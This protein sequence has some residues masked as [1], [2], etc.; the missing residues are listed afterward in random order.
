VKPLAK[1]WRLDFSAE[2][3]YYLDIIPA[4]DSPKGG[5]IIAITD[6]DDWTDS[7]PRDYAT[8]FE[9]VCALVPRFED[10]LIVESMTALANNAQIER[11]P[12]HTRFKSPLQRIV[13][14]TKRHRDYYFNKKTKQA[15]LITPSIVITT[16]LMKAYK[17]KVHAEVYS[18]GF[19][20]LLTCVKDMPN[21]LEVSEDHTG[22]LHYR[23]SNPS[24]PSENLIKKWAD[25]RYS[26]AFFAWHGDFVNFLSSLI[27][28][29]GNQRRLLA[30][31]LGER[32]VNSAF[33]RQT[34]NFSLAR[35]NGILSANSNSG[36]TL[37]TVGT[38]SSTHVIHGCK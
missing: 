23:L 27:S 8:G 31:T 17:S 26:K 36:L 10:D 33:A 19:D 3:D 25:Q 13:Q 35:Q 30:E 34:E 20:L 11:L 28:G 18:S 37:G 6:G 21:N 2:K 14:I 38:V 5:N 7:N 24:L 9:S 4:M 15:E 12:E 22:V 29:E 16:L 32:A 1:G